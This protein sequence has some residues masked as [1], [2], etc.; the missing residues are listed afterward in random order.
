[1]DTRTDVRSPVIL[2]RNY[3]H[4]CL[5]LLIA[6]RPT[7]G[8]DLLERLSELGL[9]HVDSAAVYRALR[10]LNRDGLLA[11]WWEEGQGGPVRRLYRVSRAGA[12][13]LEAWAATVGESA[14][15]L[16]AFLARHR[17]LQQPA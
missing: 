12:A 4:G 9:A 17:Q 10:A 6:E 1:M 2:P 14:S 7:Y 3:V 16:T 11:S 15:C 5:L 8:Y 13:S